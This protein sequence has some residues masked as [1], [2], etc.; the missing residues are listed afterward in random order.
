MEFIV[1]EFHKTLIE[2][3]GKAK[4]SLFI[5]SPYITLVAANKIIAAVGD[6][7]IKSRVVTRP[8]GVECITGASDFE[9]LKRLQEAGF[10]IRVLRDLHAKIYLVD[11]KVAFVGSA[12]FTNRGFGLGPAN[13]ELMVRLII[14]REERYALEEEYWNDSAILKSDEYLSHLD[15]IEFFRKEYQDLLLRAGKL[16]HDQRSPYEELLKRLCERGQI[17][18]FQ[19][20]KKGFGRNA[21]EINNKQ[22]VKM[23]RSNLRYRQDEQEGYS[24]TVAD[25]S[26]SSIRQRLVSAVVFLL[27]EPD[28]F[29][30]LPTSLAVKLVFR[31]DL[32]KQG[33]VWQFQVKKQ[34]SQTYLQIRAKRKRARLQRHRV[35]AYEGKVR[36][37]VLS[38]DRN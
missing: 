18:S 34:D 21:F 35:D 17:S 13:R 24:F 12:N 25:K 7:T 27:E 31:D 26:V 9:A 38:G 15:E 30:W 6:K 36:F 16:F 22:K 8:I 5:V 3:V 4:T 14:S 29:L 10:E 37:R 33:N 28:K 23:F 32:K 11:N 2:E 20:V 1:E 19:Q